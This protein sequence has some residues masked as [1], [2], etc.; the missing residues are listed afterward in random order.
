M[1]L[2]T[3][4][5]G[6]TDETDAP[7][8]LVANG[9]REKDATSLQVLFATSL[10]N[11]ADTTATLRAYHPS[12]ASASC[13]IDADMSQE[14]KLIGLAGWG[15]HV[16]QLV[17]FDL[18]MPAD[19]VEKCVGPSH[20]PQP[21]KERARAHKA[22]A[23]LYY[24]GQEEDVLEQYVALAAVAGC[25]GTP[26]GI[27]VLNED[28][29]TSFPAH[30]LNSPNVE[31]DRLELLRTLPLL[32][33]FCGFV[34]Y[35]I[36]G[37][38]SVW[39]RTYGAHRFGLPDLATLS[40][41]HNEGER[42]FTLFGNILNYLRDSGATMSPGHTMQAGPNTYLRCR[43]PYSDEPFLDGPG[44]TLVLETIRGDQIN[45]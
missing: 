39:M 26:D 37:S 43:A 6:T 9:D 28:G 32:I 18:P 42:T 40:R 2:F 10:P 34:K 20:Y 17:G 27:V 36:P 3:R 23:L 21:V 15:P 29:H 33:L 45:R 4:F 22:H 35:N 38:S 19:A 8:A 16:V 1:S 30:A 25:L 5:F 44:Q 14:G 13:E 41:G 11:A 12:M 31:G 7:D 24:A